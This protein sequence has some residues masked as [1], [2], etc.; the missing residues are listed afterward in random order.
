[1]P[2][3]RLA[4]LG[5][6]RIRRPAGWL[7]RLLIA[8]PAA[9]TSLALALP[10]LDTRPL[11]NDEYVTYYA[12]TLPAGDLLRLLRHVDVVLGPYYVLMHGW[13]TIFGDSEVSLRMPSVLAMASAAGLTSLLGARLFDA[14][15]GVLAGSLFVVLPAVSRYAQE[16]RPYALAMA[17]AVGATVLLFRAFERPSWTRWTMYAM[18][19]LAVGLTHCV[20]LLVLLPHTAA[21]ITTVRRGGDFRLWR[22]LAA[23]TAVFTA[24]LP[25]LAKGSHQVAQVEWIELG[26]SNLT[27]FPGRLF[28]TT[29]VGLVVIGLAI[30]SATLLWRSCRQ[31]VLIGLWWTLGPVLVCL[32]TFPVLHVFLYRYLLFTLPAWCLLFA[33]LARVAGQR[34][35]RPALLGVPVGALLLA[36]VGALAVPGQTLVRHPTATNEPDFRPA[37]ALVAADFRDGDAVAYAQ[38]DR[39]GRFA[40][41]YELRHGPRP[42]DVFVAVPSPQLGTF[43]VVDC[44]QPVRCVQDTQRIWLVA[45][46]P[47]VAD[48]YA[49]MP[50][51]SAQVL[52]DEFVPTQRW[53]WNDVTVVLLTRA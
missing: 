6:V 4:P 27:Q 20:A 43:G 19:L 23:V 47:G 50:R 7:H 37:A 35:A 48:R 33:G 9:G 42:R 12:A 40:F 11:W 1:V 8:T 52:R 41:T 53:T 5:G 22:W 10:G 21:V 15:T 13:I 34:V 44:Q 32:A 31:A 18:G 2:R 30:L 28:G 45:A 36:G 14:W 3:P 24:V 39:N 51:A 49:S 38:T 29:A 46:A 26:W 25:M 17:A 16:A